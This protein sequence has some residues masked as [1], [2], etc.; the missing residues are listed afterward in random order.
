MLDLG[1]DDTGN[2]RRK[3]VYGTNTADVIKKMDALK[4]QLAERGD[5]PTVD[6]TVGQWLA[7]WLEEIAAPRLKPT[8][9]AGYRSVCEQRLIPILGRHRLPQLSPQHVRAMHKTLIEQGLSSTTAMNAHRVLS[10]SLTDA[11]RW[12][13]VARNVASLVRAP[14]KA[15]SDRSGL[16]VAQAVAVLQVAARDLQHGSTWLVALMLGLRQGE[17]LGLRWSHVDLE[18]GTIDVAWSLARVQ[19]GY[20]KDIE[21]VELERNLVLFRPKTKTSTRVIPLP[22]LI[23]QALSGRRMWV[24]FERPD[25]TVDHDLV[26]CRPD[27]GPI[28]PRLDHAV[29]QALLA[30]A[31]VPAKTLHEARNAAA[32]MLFEGGVDQGVIKE[33]LGHSNVT[34]SRAYQRVSLELS[35]RALNEVG[36]RLALPGPD[37][38]V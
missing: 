18:A 14:S 9:L 16:T 11:V 35:R 13:R 5:L 6:A 20:R 33:I 3:T 31:G 8:T 17:R 23:V 7:Y 30:R 26:W 37:A 34:M 25:Y 28:P 19:P 10:A 21:H 15:P 1:Y 27:G 38:G 24:E 29:W 22:D 2:R 36:E 12:N 4:R 32:T